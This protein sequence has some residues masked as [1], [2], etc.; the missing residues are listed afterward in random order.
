[1]NGKEA[2]YKKRA[3]GLASR[4]V[5]AKLKAQESKT[6]RND[7]LASKR[8]IPLSVLQEQGVLSPKPKKLSKEEQSVLRLEKLKEWKKAREE[9]KKKATKSTKKPFGSGALI[10]T[11]DRSGNQKNIFLS[12][13]QW[14]S[15]S[16]VTK[17]K[18]QVKP[19]SSSSFS[20]PK[21]ALKPI[22]KPAP[23]PS[24]KTTTKPIRPIS[25]VKPRKPAI[26]TSAPKPSTKQ[27]VKPGPVSKEPK[28]QPA[29]S[30]ESAAKPVK[31]RPQTRSMTKSAVSKVKAET[32]QSCSTKIQSRGRNKQATNTTPPKRSV[33]TRSATKVITKDTAEM[34]DITVEISNPDPGDQNEPP[35]TPPKSKKYDPVTPSPLLHSRSAKRRETQF[36]V[37]QPITD[38][39]WIP[40][41]SN[42]EVFVQ[43]NF[44]EAFGNFSPFQF[45]G[46]NSS[47]QFTFRKALSFACDSLDEVSSQ[48]SVTPD[49]K[50]VR[51][52]LGSGCKNSPVRN[53]SMD[54]SAM[55]VEIINDGPS[56][57][58]MK[59]EVAT[60][61]IE[62]P[63]SAEPE[64][65]IGYFRKLH[66]DATATLVSLCKVWEEKATSLEE[67]QAD[68]KDMEE[69][70][71][72]I[73]TTICQAKLLMQQKL[74]QFFGLVD[75]AETQSGERKTTSEDLQGFWDMVYCQVE[76]IC[77]KFQG[78]EN[79]EK[80][81]WTLKAPT[82]KKKKT[83]KKRVAKKGKANSAEETE[84][85]KVAREKR[86]A[87]RNKL[88]ELKLAAKRAREEAV[89]EQENVPTTPKKSR[90]DALIAGDL[91]PKAGSGYRNGRR[92]SLRLRNRSIFS[93][94]CTERGSQEEFCNVPVA[95]LISFD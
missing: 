67:E 1:M 19:F 89:C 93:P 73:R 2:L 69:V 30:K 37:P 66:S 40:G 84:R 87:Q 42:N 44:D 95:S 75:T 14:V 65:D 68:I 57:E 86:E 33:T 9:A 46:S 81:G 90:V 94:Y 85:Q 88:R 60:T 43:P 78:L 52:S 12:K 51:K 15:S 35:T 7:L 31:L 80:N 50:I 32:K 64:I 48:Q 38:P 17:P 72:Q 76:D 18:N 59:T 13:P 71:G 77:Q 41:Q 79:I 74:K 21:S 70:F 58:E 23:K 54:E 63:E 27:A 29:K 55:I 62:I 56:E 4:E 83:A 28:R 34:M 11:A 36:F 82:P 5:R 91:S 26:S 20:K 45:G 49:T 24:F 25:G 61:P 10:S 22:E 3:Q 47:F 6:K 53:V 92:S 16:A 8:R 39:A